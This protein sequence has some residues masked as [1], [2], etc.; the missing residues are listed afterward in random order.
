MCDPTS[1]AKLLQLMYVCK[2]QQ[3]LCL[4]Q[5]VSVCVFCRPICLSPC[6]CMCVYGSMACVHRVCIMYVS[7]HSLS[8]QRVKG[9]CFFGQKCSKTTF[10]LSQNYLVLCLHPKSL[11]FWSLKSAIMGGF[12]AKFLA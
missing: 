7:G 10:T 1:S 4:K 12:S 8:Q 9:M 3:C 6:L 5:H 2:C 11:S